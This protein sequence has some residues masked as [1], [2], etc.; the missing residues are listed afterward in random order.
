M[1][2]GYEDQND[3]D[4]LRKDPLLKLVLDRL[5]E[6][7]ADLASQPTISR[8]ENT[9]GHKECLRIARE[10]GE[11]YVAQWGKEGVPR[12]VLPRLADAAVQR[13]SGSHGSRRGCLPPI[14]PAPPLP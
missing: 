1:A 7:G 6:T 12:R 4:T 13:F 14:I 2:C 10:I 3:S 8:L 11:I 5:P 9:P